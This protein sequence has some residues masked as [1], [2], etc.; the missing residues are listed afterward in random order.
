M[1]CVSKPRFHSHHLLPPWRV[2][3]GVAPVITAETARLDPTWPLARKVILVIALVQ[4]FYEGMLLLK[5]LNFIIGKLLIDDAYYYLQ[6]AWN[7][8]QLGFVTFDGVHRTNGMQFLWAVILMAMGFLAGSRLA[9]LYACLILAF[10][11]NALCYIPLYRIGKATGRSLFTIVL[12]VAWFNIHLTHLNWYLSGMENS[13][14][15]LVLWLLAARLIRSGGTGNRRELFTV[16]VLLVLNVWCRLDA[17]ALSA[18]LYCMFL[19][20]QR[21]RLSVGAVAGSVAT[22]LAGAGILLAGFYWMGG[23]PLPVSGLIKAASHTWSFAEFP[24]LAARGFEFVAPVKFL[25][26]YSFP[27]ALRTIWAPLI[28]GVLAVG[29]SMASLRRRAFWPYSIRWVWCGFALGSL[30]HLLYLS[31]LR[32]ASYTIWYQ[33]GYFLFCALSLAIAAEQLAGWLKDRVKAPPAAWRAMALAATLVYGGFSGVWVWRR[34]IE[35]EHPNNFSFARY[36]VALWIQE[37]TQPTDVLAAFNAGELAY[38]SERRVINLDGL[39]NDYAYYQKF[40]RGG[41]R[42]SDYLSAN[43]VRYLVDYQIPVDLPE[44]AILV[45]TLPDEEGNVFRVLKLPSGGASP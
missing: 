2:P 29:V 14:H 16:S 33:S 21:K 44:G 23:Y 1:S 17:A 43:G 15:A 3:G 12:G 11:L 8:A 30:V 31:G 25:F 32:V 10:C 27:L 34:A 35:G 39:V 18:I 9:L 7:T 13:L 4:I 36:R 40:I 28:F 6:V 26:P 37:N 22:A 5:G 19:W 45:H 24:L 41:G 20:A 42:L 38:F